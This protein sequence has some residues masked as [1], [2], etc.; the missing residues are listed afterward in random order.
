MWVQIPANDPYTVY[1]G[2]QYGHLSRLD[3]RTWQRD[4]I[5]PLALDAG[6]DSGYPYNWGW[7]TPILVSQHDPTVLYVGANH[8]IRDRKSTRLNSSH[9]QISYAVFCLKIKIR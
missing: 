6:L 4:D 5:T 3:L 9:S 1:S 2:W 8:L 7:T